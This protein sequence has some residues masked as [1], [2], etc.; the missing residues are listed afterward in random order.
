MGYSNVT[1]TVCRVLATV[2]N[3]AVNAV[4]PIRPMVKL[5]N[6]FFTNTHIVPN[7]KIVKSELKSEKSNKNKHKYNLV[8]KENK[9]RH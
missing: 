7:V 8:L 5:P 6:L 3:P 9:K 1:E 2:K 4:F